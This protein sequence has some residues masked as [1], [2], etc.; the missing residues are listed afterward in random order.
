MKQTPNE[1]VEQL[2]VKV[3][4]QLFAKKT[5][6][7]ALRNRW[8][9]SQLDGEIQKSITP[10]NILMIGSTGVGKTAIIRCISDLIDAPMVKVEATKYDDRAISS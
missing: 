4:G 3:I 2:G 1:F 5:I 7:V 6:A 10:K 9:R 8:R